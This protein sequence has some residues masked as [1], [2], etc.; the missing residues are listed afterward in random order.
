MATKPDMATWHGV[1]RR[2]IPWFPVVDAEKCIG[3]QLCYVTCGREVYEMTPDR[4]TKAVA[5]RPYNCMV[6]CTTCATICPT[7]AIT[8]PSRDV[9]WKVEREHKIFSVVRKEAGAKRDKSRVLQERKRAEEKLAGITTRAQIRIAGDFGEK[10]FLVKLEEA[11]KGKP[12]DVVN[13]RLEVP[14]LKGLLEKAPAHMSF[15]LTS[16]EMGDVRAF[17]DEL[18]E[19]V[20]ANALVWVEDSPT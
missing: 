7:L 11:I 5:E 6:G 17:V 14:T 12:F 8:F 1:P 19:L 10:R 16:T 3:C 9:V 13:L 2:E 20:H 18:K 4:R 15:E